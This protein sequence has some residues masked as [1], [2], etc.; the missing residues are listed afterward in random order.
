M[1]WLCIAY[2]IFLEFSNSEEPLHGGGPEAIVGFVKSDGDRP[3]QNGGDGAQVPT[4]THRHHQQKNTARPNSPKLLLQ[5]QMGIE[6]MG[7]L[8]IAC[9]VFL[10]FSDLEEPLHSG[11]PEAIVG[12]V[13]GDGD[14]P[15]QNGGDGAQVPTDTHW[16]HQQKNT[17]Q[18][19]SPK[20]LL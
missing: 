1:G 10:E 6:K 20:L 5:S 4:D 14:R 17:V 11:G 8:C 2:D 3:I 16:H 12:F 7:W 13:E 15:I 19:N 9:D 18:P